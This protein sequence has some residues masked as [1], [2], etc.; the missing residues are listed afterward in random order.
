MLLYGQCVSTRSEAP[1]S[2]LGSVGRH[3]LVR[4]TQPRFISKYASRDLH[5]LI[6]FPVRESVADDDPAGCRPLACPV[7]LRYG[8]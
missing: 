5:L 7:V 2:M 1:S 6:N 4:G 8:Y 3:A